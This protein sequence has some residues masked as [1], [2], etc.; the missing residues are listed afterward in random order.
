MLL[1][2]PPYQ[3]Q[4]MALLQQLR[5]RG[6]QDERVL[7]AIG[8]IPRHLFVD[9]GLRGRAYEDS[10]L[11][12]GKHQTIS[13]PYTVAYQTTLLNPQPGERILEIGTGSGF[14]AAVLAELGARVF[15]VERH[16]FLYERAKALLPQL[17][18]RP[19]LRH[20]DGTQG[21]LQFAPYDGIIVTAGG[22]E[23]P[24]ALLYQLKLPGGRIIIPVGAREVQTMYRI[25]R[26][27]QETFI[28]EEFEQF[29]F[30]PLVKSE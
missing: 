18:Y 19:M 21:W 27:D 15:S 7:H 25:T 8:Q 17:G 26:Q 22:L 30:V 11:P 16:A 14:Q 5:I 3:K 1:D 24:H 23:L 13:Q 9:E 28:E 10:A 20:G 2:T 6:I 12:I 4:R 29:R